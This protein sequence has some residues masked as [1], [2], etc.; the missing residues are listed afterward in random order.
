M[1]L[2]RKSSVA[3]YAQ[4]QQENSG[5]THSAFVLLHALQVERSER[6]GTSGSL[7]MRVN[8]RAAVSCTPDTAPSTPL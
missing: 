5:S 6:G 2:K 7:V 1:V 3:Y 4:D 8:V